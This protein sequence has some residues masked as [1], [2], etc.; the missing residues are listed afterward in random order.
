MDFESIKFAFD[1][2][3]ESI[4]QYDRLKN[5]CRFILVPGPNDPCSD[6]IMPNLPISEY[7]TSSFKGIKNVIFACN[8]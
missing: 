7:F 4:K 8:P 5:E 2:L 6:Q 3:A 1:K